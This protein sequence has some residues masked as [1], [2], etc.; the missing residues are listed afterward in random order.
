MQDA[1]FFEMFAICV[2]NFIIV[3]LAGMLSKKNGKGKKPLSVKALS[4]FIVL[5]FNPASYNCYG[6]NE[7]QY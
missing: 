5:F 6:K 7:T 4:V 3:T 1:V 2:I